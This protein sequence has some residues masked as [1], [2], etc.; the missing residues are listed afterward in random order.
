MDQD[1][2]LIP[3]LASLRTRSRDL[4]RNAPLAAGAINTTC[5]HVVGTGLRM[6]ASLDRSIL[7][8]SDEEANEWE[9]NTERE[10][11]LWANSQYCDIRKT[12][13]FLTIQDL[14]FRQTLENGEVFVAL[15]RRSPT[16]NIPYSLRIQLIESD[17]ICNPDHKP[18]TEKIIAGV[19]R[20]EDG[21]PVAYHILN[22]HPGNLLFLGENKWQRV[23]AFGDRTGLRNVLHPYVMKRPGQTRGIPFLAPVIETIKQIT[24]YTEAEIMAAVVSGFFTVFIKSETGMGFAP[25]AGEGTVDSGEAST[26]EEIRLGNGAVVSLRPSE[27][28]ETADPSRPNSSFDPFLKS[29][30]QQVGIALEIPFEVLI[31]HF[32]ASYSAS[33]AAL[34][35]AWRFFKGRRFWLASVFCQPVYES[36][37]YEAVSIGRIR[38]PGFFANPVIRQAYCGAIWVGDA[39]SQIDPV[40]E[41]EAAQKRVE[42]GFSTMDEET[43]AL[44]GG[45]FE[46][47]YPKMLKERKMMKKAGMWIRAEE[48]ANPQLLLPESERIRKI[49]AGVPT[50]V[51]I[52][53][54]RK[55]ETA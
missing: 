10:F 21:A 31:G 11:R 48:K 3:D 27:S 16:Y 55:D 36:W 42:F 8:I 52:K 44:T 13:N 17:R 30:L 49:P 4:V 7:N 51:E 2:A 50:P 35:E 28:I 32:S 24:R 5:T 23:P 34:L 18:D 12:Q 41:V 19:E 47:N 40:K 39:P 29:I 54:E 1:S 46:T 43:V 14:V 38:A 6:E 15:P 53:E 33:R 37:L 45:D 25:M 9:S 26:D 20:D 22:R